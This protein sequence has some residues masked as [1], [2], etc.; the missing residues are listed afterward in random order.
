[1][2]K[3]YVEFLK[4]DGTYFTREVPLATNGYVPMPQNCIDMRFFEKTEIR[5]FG[6]R[7]FTSRPKNYTEW[8]SIILTRKGMFD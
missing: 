8:E 6:I 1:M 3:R 7:I 2:R 4:D 5:I